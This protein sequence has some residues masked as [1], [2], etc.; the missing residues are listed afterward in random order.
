MMLSARKLRAVL[1]L[2]TVSGVFWG[3]AVVLGRIGYV[4]YRFGLHID[5]PAF[6]ISRSFLPGA[7]FGFVGGAI[8]AAAVALLPQRGERPVLSTGR[9]AV[10]GA[11]GGAAVFLAFRFLGPVTFHGALSTVIPTVVLSVLGA[12]FA[13]GIQGTARRGRLLDEREPGHL[14]RGGGNTP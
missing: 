13:L 5:D 3:V 7:A 6:L 14:S 11:L 1:A 2:A 4:W 9:A 8:Y 10:A 12:G